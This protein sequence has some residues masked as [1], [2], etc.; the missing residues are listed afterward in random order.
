MRR[1]RTAAL[2]LLSLAAAA[3]LVAAPAAAQ[4]S[5]RIELPNG[6]QPE[7]IAAQGTTIFAGSLAEGGIWRGDVRTGEGEVWV[8]QAPGTLAVGMDIEPGA[9]RLWVAGGPTGAIRVFDT[10]TGELLGTYQFQ[11][12]FLN[13]IAVT[14]AGVFATDSQQQQLAF[15]PIGPD[16]SLASADAVTVV[17]LSGDIVYDEGFNANGIVAVGG[18]LVIVQSNTG[19]LYRVDPASGVSFAIDTGG[20]DMTGGDGLELHGD[21]LYVV[22][23]GGIRV[24]A[25]ELSPLLDR[26]TLVAELT[27]D[28][29][30]VPTTVAVAD[31]QLWV[32]NAR[33]G[34]QAASDVPYWITRLPLRP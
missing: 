32:V 21:I 4:A 26:A 11:A 29:F 10:R 20:A 7:G 6:W 22:R 23:G 13:D 19:G 1:Q 8:Q 2:S 18:W 24:A 31:D 25:L 28:D 16:G 3:T 33:F 5:D 14:P 30:D 9:N 12:G 34:V 27:S 17:P 15:V